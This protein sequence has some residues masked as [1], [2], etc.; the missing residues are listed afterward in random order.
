MTFRNPRASH[1]NLTVLFTEMAEAT[2][3]IAQSPDM[4]SDFPSVLQR[5]DTRAQVS[6]CQQCPTE[7]LLPKFSVPMW[8]GVLESRCALLGNRA[9]YRFTGRSIKDA[10]RGDLSST[11][12]LSTLTLQMLPEDLPSETTPALSSLTDSHLLG[13]TI[14]ILPTQI[15]SSLYSLSYC[16]TPES[17]LI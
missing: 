8:T 2:D 17:Y 6:W 15:R 12:D 4:V 1:P 9:A 3:F 13:G 5:T 11:P 7:P 14:I 16:Q 10:P